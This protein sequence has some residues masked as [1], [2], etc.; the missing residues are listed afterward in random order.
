MKLRSVIDHYFGGNRQMFREAIGVSAKTLYRWLNNGAC[1]N[2]GQICL[3]VRELPPLPVVPA[4]CRRTAFE[5]RMNIV[6]PDADLSSVNGVYIDAQVQNLWEGWCMAQV[7][8][9]RT[10][11]DRNAP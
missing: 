9:L 6:R 7:E 11:I 2:N 8:V 4:D 10:A 1:V 3:P 5:M